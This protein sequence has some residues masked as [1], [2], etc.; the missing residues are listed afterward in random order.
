MRIRRLLI[1]AAGLILAVSGT[2]TT[3]GVGVIFYF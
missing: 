1:P 3:A 2:G